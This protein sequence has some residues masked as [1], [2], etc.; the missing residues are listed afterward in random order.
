MWCRGGGEGAHGFISEPAAGAAMPWAE[1]HARLPPHI[2]PIPPPPPPHPPFLHAS[3]DTCLTLAVDR[4][5]GD[6]VQ[7]CLMLHADANAATARDETALTMALRR[8]NGEMALRLV[9]YG[10]DVNVV[11]RTV[12]AEGVVPSA[13]LRDPA[14][15]AFSSLLYPATPLAIAADAGDGD[16]VAALLAAGADATLGNHFNVTPCM[17][18]AARDH[19]EVMR[20]LHAAG[21][22]LDS[23]AAGGMTAL[24]LGVWQGAGRAVLAILQAQSRRMAASGAPWWDR[25][26]EGRQ[27]ALHLAAA[28]PGTTVLAAL[29]QDL[30]SHDG[31][32]SGDGG[33][34]S[35]VTAAVAADGQVDVHAAA[36]RAG[37]V[38]VVNSPDVHGMTPLLTACARRNTAGMALLAQHGGD[39]RATSRKGLTCAMLAVAAGKHADGVAGGDAQPLVSALAAIGAPLAAVLPATGVTALSLALDTGQEALAIA[40]LEAESTGALRAVPLPGGGGSVAR[41]AAAKG[42][43]ALSRWLAEHPL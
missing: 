19:V 42:L 1:I 37:M 39:A 34:A 41:V 36:A 28:T 11:S 12:A 29:L 25:R 38:R 6:I 4:G 18:A 32:A 7:R 26:L 13:V 14:T 20:A 2:N 16:V 33:E 35:P 40:L 30:H 17:H 22:R 43:A 21:C 23:P 5:H 24:E 8:G 27:N 3:G 31:T 9:R 10:A 15:R